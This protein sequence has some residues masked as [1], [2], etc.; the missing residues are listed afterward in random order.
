M[1]PGVVPQRCRGVALAAEGVEGTVGASSASTM[2]T[3]LAIAA[4]PATRRSLLGPAAAGAAAWL[5]A[6]GE[7]QRPAPPERPGY[8]GPPVEI[9][10]AAGPTPTLF[11]SFYDRF[12]ELH[13]PRI[14][15]LSD[16]DGSPTRQNLAIVIAGGAD[17]D[18]VYTNTG[19]F[20]DYVTKG[21][22]T[23]ED[24]LIT[25]DRLDLSALYP[26]LVDAFSWQGKHYALP[27]DNTT[28]LLVYSKEAFDSAGVRYPDPDGR[29]T[30]NDLLAAAQQLTGPTGS[31]LDRYGF[32]LSGPGDLSTGWYNWTLQHG[33]SLLDKSAAHFTL[34]EPSGYEAIQWYVDLQHRHHLVPTGDDAK[35]GALKLFANGRLGM[36]VAWTWTDLLKL[37]SPR[38][39]VASLPREKVQAVRTDGA[40]FAIYRGSKKQDAAWE[41]VKFIVG[42]EG[43]R[44]LTGVGWGVPTLKRVAEAFVQEPSP[45]A[46]RAVY[47]AQ[48]RYAQTFV[49]PVGWSTTVSPALTKGL[50]PVWAGEQTARAA[51]TSLQPQIEQLLKQAAAPAA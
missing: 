26:Q 19:I 37:D 32:Y 15:V 12:N 27:K 13:A 17:V 9:R 16:P 20:R 18:V 7:V 47:V 29:W 45:P 4:L 44:L 33:G 35:Q 10:M 31:G 11:Q 51:T 50:G 2:S 48:L 3:P 5:A 34:A 21:V 40:G 6:C 22:F 43:Q 46:H 49:G 39:D 14:T 38:W 23:E 25:R 42:E 30:W 36:F 24:P 8:S 1:V 41:M 28:P